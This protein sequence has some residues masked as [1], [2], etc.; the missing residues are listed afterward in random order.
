LTLQSARRRRITTPF[1]RNLLSPQEK[2]QP[3]VKNRLGYLIFSF[4]MPQQSPLFEL[5]PQLSQF[6]PN[7][8]IQ[9][10]KAHVFNFFFNIG[11]LL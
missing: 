4:S 6:A 8:S 3:K 11:Y 2:S 7:P 9:A 10:K 5:F 1:H